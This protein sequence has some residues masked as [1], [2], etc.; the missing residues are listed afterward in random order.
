MT[1]QNG[2]ISHLLQRFIYTMNEEPIRNH[3]IT[4]SIRLSSPESSFSWLG[5]W[6][7][8]LG[9]SGT[10]RFRHSHQSVEEYLQSLSF[11]RD[12]IYVF[13]VCLVYDGNRVHYVAFVYFPTL[14]RLYSFDPGVELYRHGEKT[15]IPSIRKGFYQKGWITSKT[16]LTQQNVGRC[17]DY[18]FCGKKWGL[19]YNA[20]HDSLSSLPADAF[21]QTWTL[22]FLTRLI[23]QLHPT[24]M[25]FV[26]Q[27]CRIHPTHRE[28]FLL[29][30]FILPQLTYCPFLKKEY[31]SQL[32]MISTKEFKRAYSQLVGYAEF[33]Y[34]D[35]QKIR[36]IKCR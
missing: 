9:N 4:Q 11:R 30:F 8:E 18:S 29:S 1:K 14:H 35:Q 28:S 19:Q 13:T 22:F 10:V 7:L 24:D 36:K 23:Q 12:K 20:R 17:H 34:R 3:I 31:M 5:T 25:S 2:D 27:W 15:I 21:C 33:T 26:H 32:Q 6:N 16:L